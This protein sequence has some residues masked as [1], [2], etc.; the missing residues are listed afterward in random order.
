MQPAC[1]NGCKCASFVALATRC[2][3]CELSDLVIKGGVL[4]GILSIDINIL[5][6]V[7]ELVS[8]LKS[9]DTGLKITY[10]QGIERCQNLVSLMKG[11]NEH[12]LRIL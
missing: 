3:R 5:V 7:H 8:K 12:D 2:C 10:N 1:I 9:I 11:E 6:S 4:Q